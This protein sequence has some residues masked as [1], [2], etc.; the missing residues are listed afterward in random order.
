MQPMEDKYSRLWK[1]PVDLT[2][3]DDTLRA[4]FC[5][6]FERPPLMT[7]E[8]S[9]QIMHGVSHLENMLQSS[10]FVQQLS[11]GSFFGDWIANLELEPRPRLVLY[12][13]HDSTLRAVLSALKVFDDVWPAYASHLAI[14]LWEELESSKHYVTF[15]YNGH[16]HRLGGPCKD[17]FCEYHDFVKLLNSFRT[18]LCDEP[19]G[20]LNLEL[21]PIVPRLKPVP[22]DH[23][24]KI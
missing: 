12:S 1:F 5:H 14:E 7:K 9:E 15:Q 17:Y 18:E 24:L 2:V 20:S 23:K 13:N 3:V 16:I 6:G 8:D 22:A 4:R 11:V 19:G 21:D 10:L